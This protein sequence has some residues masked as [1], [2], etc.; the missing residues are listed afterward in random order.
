MPVGMAELDAWIGNSDRREQDYQDMSLGM[1]NT[2]GYSWD[3][4]YSDYALAIQLAD[5]GNNRGETGAPVS[6]AAAGTVY[7]LGVSTV[8]D[9]YYDASGLRKDLLTSVGVTTPLG[10]GADLAVRAYYHNDEGMGLWGTPYVT[11]PN[12]TPISIRTTEYDMDRFG[13]FADL[14]FELGMQTFTVTGW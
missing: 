5:I 14:G 6:N 11:S 2:L 13:V 9:A 3:N 8:D 12:G 1:L 4:T 7:P 10:D